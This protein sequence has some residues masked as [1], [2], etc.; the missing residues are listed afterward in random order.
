MCT[1]T[2]CRTGGRL[3]VVMNRD[4]RWGRVQE[5]PPQTIPGDPSWSAPF[6]GEKGGTWIGVNDRGVVA[7]LLN[8]Y[9]PGDF[10]LFRRDD[11]PSRGG[12]I[13]SLL[14]SEERDFEAWARED[15][16]AK[17]YPS[18][19]L[20]IWTPAGDLRVEWRLDS[21]LSCTALDSSDW[22]MMTSSAWRTDDVLAWR[23]RRFEQW[24]N[25]G[26]P[27]DGDLPAYN[28]LV[29]PQKQAWSPFMTRSFS[30]TRS[31]TRIEVDSRR[32][33]AELTWWPRRGRDSVN[34]HEPASGVRLDLSPGGVW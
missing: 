33:H 16:D 30:A 8:G 3:L 13:P 31:V 27:F 15:L 34:P 4:E 25:D 11:V 32:D 23:G 17:R 14:E 9:A 2:F 22:G 6:D 24:R 7:C 20:L 26:A 18:F 1:V 12:I 10:E 29:I 19:T 5:T 21:G 28:L